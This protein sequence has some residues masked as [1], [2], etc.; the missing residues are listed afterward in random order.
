MKRLEIHFVP[1]IKV[2][3][4]AIAYGLFELVV[5][6]GSSLG[7]WLGLS[8][9][10]VWHEGVRMVVGLRDYCTTSCG[11]RKSMEKKKTVL[12]T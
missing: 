9:L 6:V 12:F 1:R 5:D 8:F 7:L 4:H 11:L 10:G 3:Q 2:T